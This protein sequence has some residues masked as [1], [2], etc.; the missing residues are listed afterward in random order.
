M[1]RIDW[2]AAM[3]AA[4]LARWLPEL[5]EDAWPIGFQHWHFRDRLP[6][7]ADLTR[8]VYELGASVNC[9]ALARQSVE[10]PAAACTPRTSALLRGLGFADI[11]I[12]WRRNGAGAGT[13]T[14]TAAIEARRAGFATVGVVVTTDALADCQ[15][16]SALV[17]ETASHV[18][19]WQVRHDID[20]RTADHPL[21][22]VAE[23]PDRRL[24]RTAGY[25][26]LDATLAAGRLP[27]TTMGCYT[28]ATPTP[29]PQAVDCWCCDEG[30]EEIG[31][32]RIR[33]R[34]GHFAAAARTGVDDLTRRLIACVRGLMAG[35]RLTE[36][37]ASWLTARARVRSWLQAAPD[38][39]HAPQTRQRQ[40]QPQ[41]EPPAE[42]GG[43]LVP[44]AV[45]A[46]TPDLCT[47]L[48]R[49]DRRRRRRRG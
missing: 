24:R 20:A 34:Q 29:P 10:I 41:P 22:R 28:R 48:L 17:A 35:G 36:P 9:T 38:L 43:I 40:T 25:Q 21:W 47:A 14:L 23:A 49:A 42:A 11:A 4:D 6:P 26:A 45:H 27:A 32:M 15:R 1:L 31:A 37:A 13:A 30:Y 8:F 3:P 16:E 12:G 2:P 5:G 7:A 33:H 46:F 19:W 44:S 18:D 39:P